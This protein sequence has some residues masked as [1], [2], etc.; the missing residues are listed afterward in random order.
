MF[1]QDFENQMNKLIEN[2]LGFSSLTSDDANT[3]SIEL[4]GNMIPMFLKIY[5][6]HEYLIFRNKILEKLN[7]SDIIS[8]SNSLIH[9]LSFKIKS[10]IILLSNISFSVNNLNLFLNL[11]GPKEIIKKWQLIHN[12][13]IEVSQIMIH[14]SDKTFIQ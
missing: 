8:N 11:K 13:I 5:K 2:I 3:V 6:L 4:F 12:P 14:Q 1:Q 9:T 7:I 10:P